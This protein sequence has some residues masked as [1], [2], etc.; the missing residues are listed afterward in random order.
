MVKQACYSVLALLVSGAFAAPEN[1]P[2]T[3][4][5][6]PA[7]EEAGR[8]AAQAAAVTAFQ[9]L[10]SPGATLELRRPGIADGQ[11]L[12]KYMQPKDVEKAFL[13]AAQS[14]RQSDLLAFLNALDRAATAASRRP[15]KRVLMV[16]ADSPSPSLAAAM[17]GGPQEV[18]NRLAQTREFCKANAI[19]TIVI[20]PSDPSK[21]SAAALKS[22]ASE[23]AGALVRDPKTLDAS[24][25][26]IAPVEKVEAETVAS[27]PAPAGPPALTV[28]ARYFRTYP[29]RWKPGSDLG[30]MNGFLMVETP[31]GALEFQPDRSENY[32]ARVRLTQMVRNSEGKVVWQARKEVTLKAPSRKLQERRAGNLCYLR[33]LKLPAGHYALEGTVEDLVSGKSAQATEA[34]RAS[35]SLP[36]FALSDAMFVRKLNDSVDKFEA[37]QVLSYDGTA[38]A[39]MLEPAFRANEPTEVQLYFIIYPDFRGAQPRVSL[40][41]RRTDRRSGDRRSPSRTL[42]AAA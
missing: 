11:E 22:L 34:L 8:I 2:L 32:Q 38:L 20:D 17:R 9:W 23:T 28:R 26:K 39:P 10:K 24:V 30:P 25:W 37:D 16:I 6:G 19:S 12:T 13:D 42:F 5:F 4:V 31:I 27:K 7:G 3:V 41:I 35:D 1:R 40:E 29:M 18:D 33:E 36:G 15:G 21:D 14:G